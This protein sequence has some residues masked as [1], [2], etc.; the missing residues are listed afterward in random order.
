LIVSP[1]SQRVTRDGTAV[2]VEIYGDGKGAWLLEVVDEFGNST[3]WDDSF[4]TDSAA[5]AEALNVIDSEGIAAVTGSP[6]AG[7]TRH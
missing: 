5:L 6:P 7:A 2:E 1:L 3:V 4:P